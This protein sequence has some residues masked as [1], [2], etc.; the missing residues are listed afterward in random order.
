[1]DPSGKIYGMVE[2]IFVVAGRKGRTPDT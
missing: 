1:M 2:R